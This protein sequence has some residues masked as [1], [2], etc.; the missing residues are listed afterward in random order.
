MT[1]LTR[2]RK[3]GNINSLSGDAGHRIAL[4][5]VLPYSYALFS[6]PRRRESLTN[7]SVSVSVSVSVSLSPALSLVLSTQTNQSN[8]SRTAGQKAS[9]LSDDP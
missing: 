1:S 2:L 7:M 6:S 4:Q 3:R 5:N 9:E 8:H